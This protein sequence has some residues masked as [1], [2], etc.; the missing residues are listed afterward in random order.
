MSEGLKV[1]RQVQ[2][3]VRQIDTSMAEMDTSGTTSKQEE[4]MS[5]GISV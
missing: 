5:G 2:Q 1:L 4:A 3:E